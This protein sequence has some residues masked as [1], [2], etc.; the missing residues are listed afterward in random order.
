MSSSV[1]GSLGKDRETMKDEQEVESW[2]CESCRKIFGK[3][4]S[5]I[6]ECER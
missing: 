3:Q 5:K 1:R 2:I 6:L 4:E